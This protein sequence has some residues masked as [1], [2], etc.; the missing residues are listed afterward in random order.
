MAQIIKNPT[1][2][3]ETWVGKISWRS[4]W[5]HSTVFLPGESPWTEEPSGLHS[6]WSRKEL[7]TIER[8]SHSTSRDILISLR[9]NKS[10]EWK[11]AKKRRAMD[12]NSYASL[13]TPEEPIGNSMGQ[14]RWRVD[15]VELM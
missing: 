13:W 6:P 8:L 2:M 15:T 1:P 10:T 4:A 11:W 9:K 14:K 12:M 5:Q 3:Q 7:N